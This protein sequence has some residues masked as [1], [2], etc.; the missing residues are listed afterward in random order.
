MRIA[1]G[2]HDDACVFAHPP[3][4]DDTMDQ[5]DHLLER[6]NFGTLLE[7]HY[8]R[9]LEEL[10]ARHPWFVDGHAHLGNSVI[11]QPVPPRRHATLLPSV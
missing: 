4:Y 10:V 6:R 2:M 9:A 1:L 5:L 11:S 8:R 3:Q 7:V